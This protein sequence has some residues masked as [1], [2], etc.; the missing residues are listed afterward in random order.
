MSKAEEYRLIK[1]GDIQK[2]IQDERDKRAN[3]CTRYNRCIKAVNFVDEAFVFGA[4]ILG[5]AGI[6]VLSTILAPATV[7]VLESVALGTSG[8]SIIGNHINNANAESR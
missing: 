2:T 5:I 8:L 1:I 3:F 7:I 6:T 4:I